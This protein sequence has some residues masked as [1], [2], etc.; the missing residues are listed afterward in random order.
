MDFNDLIVRLINVIQKRRILFYLLFL[1]IFVG[2]VGGAYVKPARFESTA[3]LMVTLDSNRVK[4]TASDQQ[5]LSVSLQPEEIMA[6][7]VEIMQA[8]EVTEELVDTLPEWVFS[9]PPSNKWYVRLIVKPLMGLYTR[10]KN[11]LV[12]LRLI[13]PENERYERIKMIEKGLTIFPVRKAHVI[14]I[15]FRS[16]YANVPPVVVEE[17][18]NIYRARAEALRSESHG[19]EL[20][21]ERALRLSEELAEAERARAEFMIAHELTDLE[22]ERAQLLERFKTQRLKSDEERLL[23]LVELEPQLNLLDRNASILAESYMVYRK[24]ADDRKAFF[25]RDNDIA[26]KM[27]DAPTVVYQK[28]TRS[29]LVL[30]LIGFAAALVLALVIVLLV[31]W[32]VTI[33]SVYKPGSFT[34]K[35]DASPDVKAAE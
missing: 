17:L 3:T 2:A 1:S 27:I 8:R 21:H 16:K 32:I 29:R 26:A 34:S 15:S 7:Q 24:A 9:P 18:I 19:Y 11:L 6:A 12:K 4:T 5:Q 14:E 10:F 33:R 28:Y 35:R 22:R 31:E 30:V 25:E 23:K 20:Y 13:E